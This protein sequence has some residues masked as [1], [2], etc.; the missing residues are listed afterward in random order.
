MTVIWATD[1]ESD[2]DRI[3][4]FNTENND[5]AD[6]IEAFILDEGEQIRPN[7]GS[8]WT[9]LGLR[10]YKTRDTGKRLRYE[11]FLFF[12]IQNTDVEIVAVYHVREDWQNILPTRV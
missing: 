9:E 1:T 5:D 12:R 2:F 10:K 7:Y 11:Y 8:P 3:H 4:E 6:D